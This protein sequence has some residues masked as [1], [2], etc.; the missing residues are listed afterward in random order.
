MKRMSSKIIRQALVSLGFTQTKG[1]GT[2]HDTWQN[3]D[4]RTCHPVLRKRDIHLGII[5]SLGLEL[6]A[7]GVI[8]RKQ[9]FNIISTRR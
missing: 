6:E 2:G 8:S 3:K 9:F 5:Y 1:K 7:K 4:G